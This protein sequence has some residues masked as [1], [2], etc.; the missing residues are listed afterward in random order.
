MLDKIPRMFGTWISPIAK[1]LPDLSRWSPSKQHR[2]PFATWG[3]FHKSAAGSGIASVV[4]WVNPAQLPHLLLSPSFHP[5]NLSLLHIAVPCKEIIAS[6]LEGEFTIIS[7][8][9]LR[10]VESCMFHS[11][12]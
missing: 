9:A 4:I 2:Q 5:L 8:S 10:E 7:N 1:Y 12:W 3:T 6:T 11:L